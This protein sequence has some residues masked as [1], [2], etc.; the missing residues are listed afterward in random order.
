M[1]NIAKVDIVLENCE[2][3]TLDAKYFGEL[4]I[5]EIHEKVKRIA[6]NAISKMVTADVIAIEIFK[7]A[8]DIKYCPFGQNGSSKIFDRL[9]KYNDITSFT[10][11][12][13]KPVDDDKKKKKDKEVEY[14]H[15]DIYVNWYGDSDNENESQISY[16]SSQG[17]LYIII[18]KDKN[19]EDYFDYESI[20]DPEDMDFHRSMILK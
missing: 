11:Y 14:D 5:D 12:Y 18:S 17:N 10:I 3:I 2:Y 20:E 1:R 13:E 7:E 4:L 6:C 8:N 19:I 16:I 9:T 15:E